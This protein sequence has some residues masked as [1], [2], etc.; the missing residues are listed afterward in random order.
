L[1][2]LELEEGIKEVNLVAYYFKI[3]W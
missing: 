2:E 3:P 1:K